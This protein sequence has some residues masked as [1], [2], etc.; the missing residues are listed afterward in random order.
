MLYFFFFFFFFFEERDMLY[1]LQVYTH[2]TLKP[3]WL[4]FF[5][6]FLIL[7]ATCFTV[8]NFPSL[9]LPLRP[10]DL[11]MRLLHRPRSGSPLSLSLLSPYLRPTCFA[12]AFFTGLPSPGPFL[13]L[14]LVFPI[15]TMLL[16]LFLLS[17]IFHNYKG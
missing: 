14:R 7:N 3:T 12:G 9:S 2:L 13:T 11:H 1:L 4:E 16:L 10:A 6:F 17:F 5:F 8:S 15:Q